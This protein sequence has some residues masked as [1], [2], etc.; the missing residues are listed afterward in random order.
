MGS[1]GG[2][3]NPDPLG[4]QGAVKVDRAQ[5][6]HRLVEG[7]PVFLGELGAHSREL[8]VGHYRRTQRSI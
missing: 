6:A 3:A 4:H 2:D 5:L 8:A 7:G 1:D